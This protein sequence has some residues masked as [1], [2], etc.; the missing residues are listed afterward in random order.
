MDD[1]ICVL[2]REKKNYFGIMILLLT[3]HFYLI[4]FVIIPVITYRDF[5][6]VY[7]PMG[8]GREYPMFFFAVILLIAF[9]YHF[10][11]FIKSGDF[12]LYAD[13]IE[14]KSTLAKKTYTLYYEEMSV[15][16]YE[17]EGLLYI[18]MRTHLFLLCFKK[19]EFLQAYFFL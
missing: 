13:R 12:F 4:A 7:P 15:I 8:Y 16:L 19:I 10:F 17:T 3:I 14:V 11:P 5:S 2:K 6:A 1:P 9:P 18:N